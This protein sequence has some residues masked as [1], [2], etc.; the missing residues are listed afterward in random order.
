[1]A[2]NGTLVFT[3]G[4]SGTDSISGATDSPPTAY[5][6]MAVQSAASLSATLVPLSPN[7]ST[8]SNFTLYLTVSDSGD[9]SAQVLPPTWFIN[10]NVGLVNNMQ[11]QPS[12]ATVIG[13]SSQ[14]FTYSYAAVHAGSVSFSGTVT[15]TDLNTST[16]LAV[17]VGP[18]TVLVENP[19]ALG[20]S[21]APSFPTLITVGQSIT[22][23]VT[24]SN[25][26]SPPA[27]QADNVGPSLSVVNSS[28]LSL[29]QGAGSVP[30]LIANASQPFTYIYNAIGTGT[31]SFFA[32][33]NG[34][35]DNSGLPISVTTATTGNIVIQQ[36]GFLTSVLS[37][38]PT[39]LTPAGTIQASLV[40]TN[41]GG[42]TVTATT[43]NILS[44]PTLTLY[45]TPPSA[46][47]LG[48][49]QSF[50][51]TWGFSPT[52]TGTYTVSANASGTDSVS[53]LP[54]VSAVSVA[55]ASVK[56]PANLNSWMTFAPTTA[57]TGENVT[58]VMTVSNTGLATANNVVP[59]DVFVTDN[60]FQKIGSSGQL[61]LPTGPLPASASIPGLGSVNFTFIYHLNAAGTLSYSGLAD[62]VDSI[63]GNAISSPGSQSNFI[64]IVN[65]ANLSSS[66][67]ATPSQ[68]NLYNI[69]TV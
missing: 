8:G 22:L 1:M 24:L 63:Q 27:A 45:T 38:T 60:Y 23:V 46:Q 44:S 5:E 25:T 51:F 57:S 34:T 17:T 58:L 42:S 37:L 66:I 6:T 33:S 56:T 29:V 3:G 35:D 19:A 40:V 18:T 10:P 36:P 69:I 39:V 54:V 32:F 4:A 48:P 26:A 68:V 2:G 47:N 14:T 52:T 9:A 11:V 30:A 61:G 12:V 7:A 20:I 64:N 43:P 59:R 67:S 13:H 15:G 28:L 53:G 62:G 55:T 49:N 16:P 21:I 65:A 31:V 50:T 41:S